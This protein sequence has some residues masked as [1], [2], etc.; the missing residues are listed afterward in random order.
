[1]RDT[2]GWV[3]RRASCTSDL[4]RAA[5]PGLSTKVD[6]TAFCAAGSFRLRK[7]S[8]ASSLGHEDAP[9][10]AMQAP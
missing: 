7:R 1:M 9:F 5:A 6:L 8:T 10:K 2:L 4:S 3:T